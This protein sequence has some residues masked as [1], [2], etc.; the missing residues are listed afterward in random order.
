[1]KKSIQTSLHFYALEK[2]TETCLELENKNPA[3]ETTIDRS[4]TL[5]S[6]G[7]GIVE[8]PHAICVDESLPAR[9]DVGDVF[10]AT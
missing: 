1:M 10:D 8:N 5:F 9:L 6:Y 3:E 2:S 7:R 4:K